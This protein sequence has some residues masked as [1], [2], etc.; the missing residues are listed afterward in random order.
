MTPTAYKYGDIGISVRLMFYVKIVI[1]DNQS[2]RIILS[3]TRWKAFIERRANVERLV[4]STVSSSLT[5]QD[6]IM[7]L[8]KIGNEYN[9]KYKNI[10]AWYVL[11]H[12]AKNHSFH[13]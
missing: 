12:E 2:N 7:E 4:Q 9:V 1:D 13:V 5:I 11:A 8:V 3:H 10:I 6:L